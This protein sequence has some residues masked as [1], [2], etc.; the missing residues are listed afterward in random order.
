MGNVEML[1]G[2]AGLYAHKLR[3]L[4]MLVE[5]GEVVA[6]TVYWIT[7]GLVV[8]ESSFWRDERPNSL[9]RHVGG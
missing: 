6:S 1:H 4:A 8:E 7:E 3:E 5:A 2:Q 9:C